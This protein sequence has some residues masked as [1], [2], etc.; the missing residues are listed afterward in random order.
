MYPT[1][2]YSETKVS[3]EDLSKIIVKP[4][5]RSFCSERNVHR[6]GIRFKC[7][8]NGVTCQGCILDV[9]NQTPLLNLIKKHKIKL[10]KDAANA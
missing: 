7:P 9:D 3:L 10:I 1:Y 6:V 2:Q 5:L 8:D 4:H